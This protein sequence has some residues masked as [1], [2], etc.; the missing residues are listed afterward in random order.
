MALQEFIQQVLVDSYNSFTSS[1]PESYQLI[2]NIFIYTILIAL[3][4]IFVF[5]FYRFLARKN[6]ITLNLSQ[7]NTSNYPALK[8][9]FAA[10]FF[11]IEYIIILPALVFFWFAILAFLLLLLSKGQSVAQ[12]LLVAAAVVGAIR[13]TSY[14]REDLSRDLAKMFPFTVLAIFLLGPNFLDFSSVI[15]KLLEVPLFLNNIVF[16]LIFVIAFEIFIRFIYTIVFLFKHPEEQK[17]Q[18]IEEGIKGK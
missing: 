5:E 18:E 7:Y 3:Y 14:F 9:F 8:K 17:M 11:L 4:S 1:L 16:Y 10:L 6:I 15:E 12:I 13:V 2:L